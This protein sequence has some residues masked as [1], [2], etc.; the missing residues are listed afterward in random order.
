MAN[1][2]PFI[3]TG[4]G[5]TLGQGSNSGGWNTLYAWLSIYLSAGLLKTATQV[6]TSDVYYI[7]VEQKGT[8]FKFKLQVEWVRE[9][10]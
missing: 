3:Y 4:N 6:R 10:K 7:S 2:L 1:I 5:E 9:K 8:Q